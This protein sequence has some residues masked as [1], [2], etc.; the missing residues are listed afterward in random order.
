MNVSIELV[1]AGRREVT[2]REG[3]HHELALA[4]PVYSIPKWR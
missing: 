2:D 3:A 4:R 1:E